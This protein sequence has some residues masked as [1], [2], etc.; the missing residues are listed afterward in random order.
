MHKIAVSCI[1]L[2]FGLSVNPSELCGLVS[3]GALK[4]RVCSTF[5]CS[6]NVAVK[7]DLVSEGVIELFKMHKI[8]LH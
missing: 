8:E 3:V 6:S 5:F 1:F 2:F 4:V 7:C